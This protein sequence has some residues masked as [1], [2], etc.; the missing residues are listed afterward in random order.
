[1]KKTVKVIRTYQIELTE[2][3]VA[4]L[5]L[6]L[7]KIDSEHVNELNKGYGAEHADSIRETLTELRRTLEE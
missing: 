4:D 3:Q 2:T 5:R 6:Y 1:M 7:Q